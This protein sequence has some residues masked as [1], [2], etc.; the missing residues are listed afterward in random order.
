MAKKNK[1]FDAGKVFT[2]VMAA[3][4][5]ILMVGGI[6]ATLIFYIVQG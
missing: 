5:A 2:R 1:K 3:V 6:S 4:L